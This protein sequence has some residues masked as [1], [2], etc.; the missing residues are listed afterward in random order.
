MCCLWEQSGVSL[1]GWF[2]PFHLRIT[3]YTNG[4]LAE[5]IF[6]FYFFCVISAEPIRANSFKFRNGDIKT[7]CS[8]FSHSLLIVQLRLSVFLPIFC[9]RKMLWWWPSKMLIYGYRKCCQESFHPYV[10]LAEEQGLVVSYVEV[11]VKMV[12]IGTIE[13]RGFH[14]TRKNWGSTKG[15]NQTKVTCVNIADEDAELKYLIPRHLFRSTYPCSWCPPLNMISSQ[16]V[17]Y[18]AT[19]R[20]I[21]AF[22]LTSF[23]RHQVTNIWHQVTTE[24]YAMG[25]ICYVKGLF[26]FCPV[27][28]RHI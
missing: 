28:K 5:D 14:G 25:T 13:S 4:Y 2:L 11:W 26:F 22:T 20:V 16:V 10:L 15:S 21:I 7:K 9:R 1:Q 8:N 24:E 17:E 3:L 23:I 12:P 18:A 19:G 27:E 6:W